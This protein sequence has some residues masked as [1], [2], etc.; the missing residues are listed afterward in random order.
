MLTACRGVLVLPSVVVIK[1]VIAGYI[2]K[3]RTDKEQNQVEVIADVLRAP[4]QAPLSR[5]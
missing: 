5:S 4:E 1:F 3:L 2:S